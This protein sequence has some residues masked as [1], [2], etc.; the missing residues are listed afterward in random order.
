MILCTGEIQSLQWHETVSL[1]ILRYSES[2][3]Q[4]IPKSC[5]PSV[6]IMV[7]NKSADKVDTL[8]FK[9]YSAFR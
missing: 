3:I 5:V 9:A 1:L 6:R 2:Y 8:H 4:I 7:N